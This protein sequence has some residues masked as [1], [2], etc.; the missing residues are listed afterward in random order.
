M[1]IVI[2]LNWP[3]ETFQVDLSTVVSLPGG[4]EKPI[5]KPLKKEARST[6]ENSCVKL[7]GIQLAFEAIT[8][9]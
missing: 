5:S 1:F 4:K 6:L 2:W 8:V 7:F 9:V 3:L